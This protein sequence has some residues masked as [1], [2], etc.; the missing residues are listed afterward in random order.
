LFKNNI[1]LALMLGWQDVRQSYRRS[2]IGPF[3]VTITTGVLIATM[4]FVFGLLFKIPYKDYLPYL[5]LGILVWNFISGVISEASNLFIGS[6]DLV[7]QI[8][9]PVYVYVIRLVW[10]AFV[11]FLHNIILIPILYLVLQVPLSWTMLVAFIGLVLVLVNLGWIVISLGIVA[12][13]YR[14]FSQLTTSFLTV[15]FYLTPVMWKKEGLDESVVNILVR[16]NPFS[17]FLSLIRDPMLGQFPTFHTWASACIMAVV[18]W[19]LATFIS[20]RYANRVVYWL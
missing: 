9:L 16:Y 15:F 4:G 10:R 8:K 3:W 13:R 5:A 2:P 17:I 7:K 20:R 19:A 11:I 6:A 18:G 1:Q 14:D 12:T